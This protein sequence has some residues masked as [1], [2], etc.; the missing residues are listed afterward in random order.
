MKHSANFFDIFSYELLT[1]NQNSV[2]ETKKD[3]VISEELALKYFGNSFTGRT[4]NNTDKR[5]YKK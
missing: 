3:I 4:N 2:L 1:N 5:K